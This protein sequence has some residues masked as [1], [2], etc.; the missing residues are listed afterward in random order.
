MERKQHVWYREQNETKKTQS[1]ETMAMNVGHEQDVATHP[2]RAEHTAYV[3]G[4][5]GRGRS[6]QRLAG[7]RA[8]ADS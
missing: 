4:E 6:R 1:F 5:T 7:V 3:N 8:P 2:Q